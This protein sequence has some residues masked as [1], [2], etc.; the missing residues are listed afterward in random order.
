MAA[1]LDSATGKWF[2]H[3]GTGQK[4]LL[5]G[6]MVVSD[7]QSPPRY[8]S[9]ADAEQAEDDAVSY[10]H[11]MLLKLAEAHGIYGQIETSK[12]TAASDG[13]KEKTKHKN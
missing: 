10:L 9:E 11:N 5:L 4:S 13:E 3:T 12:K 8:T 7:H 6:A 2:W 1:Q